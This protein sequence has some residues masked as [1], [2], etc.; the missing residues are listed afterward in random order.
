MT[1]ERSGWRD[2]H[3]RHSTQENTTPPERNDRPSDSFLSD[4]LSD[5]TENSGKTPKNGT[6]HH[7][8]RHFYVG[9]SEQQHFPEDIYTG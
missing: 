9:R 8:F 2:L 1:S 7:V 6:V 5:G 4:F 3:V